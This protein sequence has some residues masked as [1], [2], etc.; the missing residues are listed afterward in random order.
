MAVFTSSGMMLEPDARASSSYSAHVCGALADEPLE[1]DVKRGAAG[2]LPALNLSYDAHLLPHYVLHHFRK[3]SLSAGLL[4]LPVARSLAADE[5]LVDYCPAQFEAI[6]SRDASAA[7]VAAAARRPSSLR[8]PLWRKRSANSLKT[9]KHTKA[10]QEISLAVRESGAQSNLLEY[11]RPEARPLLNASLG[12]Q[13]TMS[14]VSAP[15]AS[16]S[17]LP[18]PTPTRQAIRELRSHSDSDLDA[19]R[20]EIERDLEF[21]MASRQ[22]GNLATLYASTARPIPLYQQV[23]A[24]PQLPLALVHVSSSLSFSP[25]PRNAAH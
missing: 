19:F 18:T 1:F 14:S 10:A 7:A 17:P 9:A 25:E 23:C 15:K 8:V 24:R 22:T 4:P 3:R 12:A 16:A 2:A 11:W 20:R 21:Q 13:Q 5:R 6:S